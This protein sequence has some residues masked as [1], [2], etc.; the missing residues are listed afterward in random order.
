MAIMVKME[1]DCFVVLF[2]LHTQGRLHE[3]S[4]RDVEILGILPQKLVLEHGIGC[5]LHHVV[6]K[7]AVNNEMLTLALHETS[8]L[9]VKC[10]VAVLYPPVLDVIVP[11][12]GC[13]SGSID[14][15]EAMAFGYEFR[16]PVLSLNMHISKTLFPLGYDTSPPSFQIAQ[17]V[18]SD[19]TFSFRSDLG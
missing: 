18:F 14:A 7:Q 10:W 6:H 8:L 11:S 17:V 1:H 4:S 5:C 2:D 13:L 15:L 9:A 3:A 12:T 16:P 19:P